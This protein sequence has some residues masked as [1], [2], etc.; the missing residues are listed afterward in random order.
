MK[1]T[2]KL[3]NAKNFHDLDDLSDIER[4]QKSTFRKLEDEKRDM[5]F[6]IVKED[7]LDKLQIDIQK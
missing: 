3:K 5:L 2:E 1:K 7:E 4:S 6:Q